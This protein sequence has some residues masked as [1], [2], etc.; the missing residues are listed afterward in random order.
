M[1]ISYGILYANVHCVLSSSP[2]APL[3]ALRMSSGERHT[4]AV[5]HDPLTCQSRV[6]LTSYQGLLGGSVV[7]VVVT[8]VDPPDGTRRRTQQLAR[9]SLVAQTGW[10]MQPKEALA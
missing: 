10:G 1:S 2:S 5:G 7:L 4:V 6:L 9:S 8:V 3:D